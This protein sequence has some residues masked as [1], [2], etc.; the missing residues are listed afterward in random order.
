MAKEDVPQPSSAKSKPK[1]IEETPNT[2]HHKERVTE[3]LEELKAQ[4]Q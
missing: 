1:K 4:L 3:Q 2:I